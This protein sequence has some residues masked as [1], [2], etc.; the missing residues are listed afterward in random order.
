MM[1]CRDCE[2]VF[3]DPTI[4]IIGEAHFVECPYCHSSDI[5][6][7]FECEE[8]GHFITG[9]YVMIHGQYCVCEECYE[10]KDIR[11]L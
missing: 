1:F 5:V 6:E 8:C 7:T 4:Q 10:R 3:E 2:M 11:L 9:E